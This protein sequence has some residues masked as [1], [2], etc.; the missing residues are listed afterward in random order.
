MI[1]ANVTAEMIVEMI[2]QIH[3]R[4]E[5]PQARDGTNHPEQS[6]DDLAFGAALS[7]LIN[8]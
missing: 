8:S 5:V 6:D 4:G 7:R 2:E 1:S 3:E